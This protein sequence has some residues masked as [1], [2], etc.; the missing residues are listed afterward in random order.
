MNK[1]RLVLF[2][3]GLLLAFMIVSYLRNDAPKLYH[4]VGR[5]MGTIQYNVKYIGSEVSGLDQEIADELVAFNQSLS[6]YIPTSEVSQLNAT[7]KIVFRSKYFSFILKKSQEIYDR[8]QRAFDPSVGPLIQAWG[9]GPDKRIPNLDSTAVDS[10]RAIT[11]F[12]RIVFDDEKT[13]IPKNFQ[14]DFSAIAKGYAVDVIAELLE[15]K[16][17]KNYMVEIGGEVRCRGKNDEQKSWAL[18][19]EDPM[20]SSD[21]QRLMAIV[22][23]KDRALATSGNYRNFYEK[24][25]QVYAHII[26][27]RTGYTAKHNLLSASVFG[28]DCMTA[29]AYATAFMVLGLEKSKKIAATEN[30]DAFFLYR[31]ESG[32]IKSFVTDGIKPFLELNK[33]D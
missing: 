12:D 17:V 18:G 13:T 22:R 30:L 15:M 21:Q 29:D 6:T 24:D 1:K 25:G 26:D 10:L 16:G 20:V 7:G 27:P 33:A 5:T 4:I 9:F 11:G 31:S 28:A 2:G 14:I 3:V 32:N 23:L 19:I 8:T